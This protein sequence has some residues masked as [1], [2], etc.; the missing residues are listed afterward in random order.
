VLLDSSR[1]LNIG[2]TLVD[3]VANRLL[4]FCEALSYDSELVV[5]T[6]R[7]LVESWASRPASA[8]AWRSEI[9]DDNT[10]IELSVAFDRVPSLRIL[11]EPQAHEPSLGAQ[12]V[13]GLRFHERLASRFGADLAR[14]DRVR[15]LFLPDVMQGAF[16]VWS[17]AVFTPSDAPSF[18]AYL[19]PNAQGRAAAPALVEEALARLGLPG[20]WTNL[21]EAATRRG[22]V[23]DEIKY[24][25]LDLSA[26]AHA[27][28]KVY[29]HHHRATPTDL[30]AA[31]TSS[32]N[33][34]TGAVRAFGRAMAGGDAPMSARAPFTCH[35]FTS[36]RPERATVTAYVPVCA[37]AHDDAVV[38]RRFIE[39]LDELG[40]DSSLYRHSVLATAPRSLEAGV[41]LQS[42]IALRQDRPRPRHTVYIATEARRL[43]PPGT[44]P[45]PSGDPFA[46][47]TTTELQA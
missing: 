28:V 6:F 8:F 24:F 4:R 10:P 35:S 22:P 44:V 9:S 16:A 2:V 13:A 12:R 19:N 17:S 34:T 30:E 46:V 40:I 39:H 38:A 36:E 21:C 25:A 23:L 1:Y 14:F 33:Y 32:A 42:W 18:K 43:F 27:R 26:D 37:Y 47:R 15:D 41:G 3:H 7:D 20:A 31:C 45:A 11:L 5:A 29:V